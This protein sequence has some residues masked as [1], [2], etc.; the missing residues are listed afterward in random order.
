[1]NISFGKLKRQAL[2][3]LKGKWKICVLCFFIPFVLVFCGLGFTNFGENGFLDLFLT[4]IVYDFVSFWF[5]VEVFVILLRDDKATKKKYDGMRGI[6]A[7]FYILKNS[8][9]PIMVTKVLFSFLNL[10]FSESVQNFLYDNL[11]FSYVPYYA[12]LIISNIFLVI[13]SFLNLYVNLGCAIVP[14]IMAD[15]PFLNGRVAMKISFHYLKGKKFRVFLLLMSLIGWYVLGFFALFVGVFFAMAYC[16]SVLCE[17]YKEARPN[18][19]I[20]Y[21]WLKDSSCNTF[22]TQK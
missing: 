5:F 20:Q 11:L 18:I 21:V 1:M 16:A 13:I 19:K 22:L 3:N 12:F 2:E 4:E 8:F 9:F 10:I 17:F 7:P 15:N 14:C 6:L